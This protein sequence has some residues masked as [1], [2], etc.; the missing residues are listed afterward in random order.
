MKSVNPCPFCSEAELID[1]V[2]IYYMMRT[3]ANGQVTQRQNEDG[4]H[5][6]MT[7]CFKCE[8][9]GPIANTREE[10]VLLWNR[11]NTRVVD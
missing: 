5:L 2:P 1:V 3:W 8:T 10:A 11:R 6:W 7:I 4:S 9:Q